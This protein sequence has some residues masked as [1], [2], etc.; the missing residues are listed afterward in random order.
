M[1]KQFLAFQY[2]VKMLWSLTHPAFRAAAL[3]ILVIAAVL[4]ATSS[5]PVG[6][7]L[8]CGFV[9]AVIVISSIIIYRMI[10]KELDK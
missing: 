6:L 2:T 4:I 1:K 8:L 9:L 5:D 3:I 10:A 7:G